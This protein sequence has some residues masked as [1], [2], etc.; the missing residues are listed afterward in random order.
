MPF[1]IATAISI[2]LSQ[3]IIGMGVNVNNLLLESGSNYLQ[4]SGFVFL[5]E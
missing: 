2:P 5:L 4:E 1:G 3:V